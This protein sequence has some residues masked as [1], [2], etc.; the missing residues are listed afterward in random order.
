MYQRMHS[1]V[2]NARLAALLYFHVSL[3]T[4]QFRCSTT[5]PR[6]IRRENCSVRSPH[7]A[8]TSPPA[9]TGRRHCPHH[10][11]RECNNSLR[12]GVCLK[13]PV[14]GITRIH[15]GLGLYDRRRRT[16]RGSRG[17]YSTRC[18][19]HPHFLPQTVHGAVFQADLTLHP[20]CLLAVP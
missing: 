14:Y 17:K 9:L 4:T 18:S 5:Y 8:F 19:T 15:L 11:L 6:V 1:F 10:R 7:S 12:R 3:R 2:G 13:I 20:Q 16:Q